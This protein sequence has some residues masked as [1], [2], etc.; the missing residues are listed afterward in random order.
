MSWIVVGS[1]VALGAYQGAQQRKQIERQNR[2]AAEQT[3]WSPWTGMGAGQI[4]ADGSTLLG[5]AMKGGIQG[6]SLRGNLKQAGMF[7]PSKESFANAV[8]NGDGTFGGGDGYMRMSRGNR[9]R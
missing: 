6:V 8:D 5:D 7:D 3:R 1:T 9:Q 2:A 4:Q